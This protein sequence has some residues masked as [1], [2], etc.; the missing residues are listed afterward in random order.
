MFDM[1]GH[2]IEVRGLQAPRPMQ[3]EVAD[4]GGEDVSDLAEVRRWVSDVKD[5]ADST[6]QIEDVAAVVWGED[7]ARIPL[8]VFAADGDVMFRNPMLTSGHAARLEAAARNMISVIEDE[9]T[10]AV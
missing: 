4:G 1:K 2:K 10:A 5:P 8:I 3:Q 6:I 7:M 9:Q